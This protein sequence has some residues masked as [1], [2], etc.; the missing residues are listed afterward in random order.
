MT[1]LTFEQARNE[2]EAKCLYVTGVLCGPRYDLRFSPQTTRAGE[3]NLVYDRFEVYR[4]PFI[5]IENAEIT[6]PLLPLD[7]NIVTVT[8]GSAERVWIMLN[9]RGV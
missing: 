5:R 6:A 7:G 9:S 1:S 2:R 3:R 8:P 4:E